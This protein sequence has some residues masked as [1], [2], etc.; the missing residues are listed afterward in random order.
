MKILFFDYWLKGIANFERLVP[1]LQRQGCTDLK[2]VHVGSWKAPQDKAVHEHKGFMSYDISY[3]HTYSLLTVL[4]REKPDALLIL[5]LYFLM[6]KALVVFCKKLGIKVIYLA[7]GRML[8]NNDQ[9]SAHLK[10]DLKKGFLA[11]VRVDTIATLYNYW[12]S[13]VVS[14]KPLRFFRS[15]C[16][17]VKDPA[18]MT[19]YST[20]TDELAADKLLLY[21]ESDKAEYVG[22]RK[23]PDRNMTVVGN[24]E[25]DGYVQSTLVDRQSFLQTIG[26]GTSDYLL[27]LDD[28]HVQARVM[29]KDDWYAMLSVLTDI[30]RRHGLTLVAKLHPRTDQSEHQAFF[31]K[32]GIVALKQVDFRNIVEHSYAVTSL[33]STTVTMPIISGKR[34]I[35]PRWGTFADFN[36]SYPEDVIRYVYTPA[37]FE[38]AL[39]SDAPTNRCPDYLANSI[40]IVDGHAIER[41]V[42]EILK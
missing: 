22:K 8:S 18:S 34:V 35:S 27:Y 41:I 17:L 20:Y 28:G 5:N 37:E 39:V 4:K 19:L 26:V 15:L 14:G 42:R 11:K 2:M 12:L 3:Y 10:E 40:G 6:D 7:H 25:L 23:F 31:D 29:S 32:E 38:Q 1:E 36:K 13:T 16:S 33:L 30:C 9:S 21:Y 24:P